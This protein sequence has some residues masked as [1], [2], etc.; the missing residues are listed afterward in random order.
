MEKTVAKKNEQQ[1][2]H[3]GI[4]TDGWRYFGAHPETRNGTRG[5]RFRTWAP[6][7]Q[8]VSIVG[9]FN[10]WDED[11]NPLKRNGELWEGF[12][13]GLK[14]FDTYKLAV[15]GK[16]G[17]TRLKADPYGFHTETRPATASKLYDISG[18]PWSDSAFRARRAKQPVYESPL[19]I[20]E[21]HLGSWRLRDNGDFIDY[22]DLAK[23][24]AAYVRDMG[25]TA[26]ELLPVTEHPLDD[27]WG[28]QCTGYFAPTSRYGT[29]KD[30][31]WFVN[32]MHENGITVIL[33]WVPSH[34]CK[35][36]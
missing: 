14:E 31:M 5:W 29:P 8:G 25:Y 1:R 4:L 18:F 16:D 28:Y 35:D 3:E 36:A 2:F 20:Y 26:I 9:E 32:H 12:I 6:R 22:R 27:S 23:Q 34:F 19:N 21:V 30:F 15:R 10:N 13:P 33:D 24:L 17:V 7:A 11:A